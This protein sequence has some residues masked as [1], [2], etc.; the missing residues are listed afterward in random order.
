MIEFM[1]AQTGLTCDSYFILLIFSMDTSRL[2]PIP[3][4]NIGSLE[5]IKVVTISLAH[6][7]YLLFL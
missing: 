3:R 7:Y 2:T 4:S 5:N 1:V 6:G